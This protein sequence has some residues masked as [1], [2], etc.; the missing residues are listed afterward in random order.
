LIFK[1]IAALKKLQAHNNFVKG[2]TWDPVGK[3]LASQSDDKRVIVWRV[4]DWK[5]EKSLVGPFRQSEGTAFFYRLNWS[6]DGSHIA[7]AHAFNNSVPVAMLINRDDWN[8][9]KSF[10]GHA[11]PVVVTRFSPMIY[12]KMMIWNEDGEETTE[13]YTIC[14]VGSEDHSLSVWRSDSPRPLV[15]AKELFE[16]A[17]LDLSWTA[18]GTRLLA[19]SYDGSIAYIE[20]TRQE[21]GDALPIHE[22]ERVLEKYGLKRKGF[23]IPESSAQL[24]L[25]LVAKTL[26]EKRRS[27]EL[28][29]TSKK[30]I[31]PT[32]ESSNVSRRFP[33]IRQQMET[34]TKEGRKR[35]IPQFVR[36]LGGEPP[37]SLLTLS[38]R[39]NSCSSLHEEGEKIISMKRPGEELVSASQTTLEASSQELQEHEIEKRAY[40]LAASATTMLKRKSSTMIESNPLTGISPSK[41]RTRPKS[42]RTKNE[43]SIVMTPQDLPTTLSD[44]SRSCGM[45]VSHTNKGN[46]GLMI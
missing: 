2:I 3:Y 5:P 22:R 45:M 30:L 31:L 26:E 39:Q 7:T 12:R 8:S 4:S 37:D 28:A 40:E 38:E 15:V 9:D 32:M 19:C 21:C 1:M 13:L 29:A 42:T 20:F 41:K 35:I 43:E 27:V 18:D 44:A 36:S 24:D 10:V 6:P 11:A 33:P 16:H 25:E 34:K 17:V 46:G 23:V 14:A